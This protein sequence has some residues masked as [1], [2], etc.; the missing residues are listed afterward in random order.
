MVCG[1]W[2]VVCIVSCIACGLHGLGGY[3][4]RSVWV[5]VGIYYYSSVKGKVVQKG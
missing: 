3:G 4:F 5:G 1:V 2:C